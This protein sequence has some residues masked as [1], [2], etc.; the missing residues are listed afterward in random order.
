MST[1][2]VIDLDLD[3]EPARPR[4]VAVILAYNVRPLLE[5]ALRKIPRGLVDAVIVMDDGS[6]DGTAEEARRL[7]LTVF[8]NERNLGY[9]GNLRRGLE[10]A[11]RDFG[12][13]YVVE[14]HGDG[15]QFDPRAIATA[16]PLMNAGVPFIMGS[17]FVERGAARRFGMPWVRLLANRGLSALSRRVLALPLTEF[18]SGFRVYA[19]SF[20]ETLP[21]AANASNHL[22]SFQILAQAAYFGQGVGEV[23]VDA[24]YLSA[25][26]SISLRAAT[27]YAFATLACM[28]SYL[29]AKLGLRHTAVF[30]AR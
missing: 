22:F 17:R 21:L 25:H 4:V 6:T 18:H 10:R 16:V 9:G 8:R 13:E 29:L 20:V 23:P 24:D 2:R 7:G 1:A 26:S 15:A 14:I 27:R 11:V 28:A 19:R 30:P 5:K 12:A 3:L